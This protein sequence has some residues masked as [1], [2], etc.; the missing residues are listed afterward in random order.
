M[1]LVEHQLLGLLQVVQLL[2]LLYLSLQVVDTLSA[3]FLHQV[4]VVLLHGQLQLHL[5]DGELVGHPVACLSG[6]DERVGTAH[7]SLVNAQLCD[8]LLEGILHRRLAVAAGQQDIVPH[9]LRLFLH[10]ACLLL[11]GVL[12]GVVGLVQLGHHSLLSLRTLADLLRP[13]LHALLT[14]VLH[15]LLDARAPGIL[16]LTQQEGG[17]LQLLLGLFLVEP[18]HIHALLHQLVALL[19]HVGRQHTHRHEVLP[20]VLG[21]T[22]K[23]TLL[24]DDSLDGIHLLHQCLLLL[25]VVLLYSEAEVGKPLVYHGCTLLA[26]LLYLV[27]EPDGLLYHRLH[28]LL[29]VARTLGDDGE[30]SVLFFLGHLCALLRIELLQLRTA[31][32]PLGVVGY[33]TVLYLRLADTLLGASLLDTGTALGIVCV[34]FFQISLQLRLELLVR[35]LLLLRIH[36]VAGVRQ[37]AG[38][39]LVLNLQAF[40]IVPLDDG[41]HI[42]SHTFFYCLL[43][44]LVLC[45]DS[46][47]V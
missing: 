29:T 46:L 47:D 15:H 20:Q 27:G 28:E 6:T 25:Q 11:D 39:Q 31:L 16:R 18:G 10:Q 43:K 3:L 34:E 37:V 24:V 42:R 19:G 7:S 40:C 23:G 35:I 38:V 45:K 22:V 8:G 9:R 5:L 17:A 26:S 13:G 30:D 33:G 44:G 41:A 14:H 32:M 12:Y 4:K 2:G 1:L 21:D 36:P